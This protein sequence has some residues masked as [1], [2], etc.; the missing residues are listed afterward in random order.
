MLSSFLSRYAALSRI[1]S[2][3]GISAKLN[4]ARVPADR[5]IRTPRN[6][7]PR[8]P[9]MGWCP[10]H[11]RPVVNMAAGDELLDASG[12]VILDASGNVVLSDGAGDGCCCGQTC[13]SC[14]ISNTII[15]AA[16]GISVCSGCLD[17]RKLHGSPN[18]TWNVPYQATVFGTCC[19]YYSHFPGVI[20]SSSFNG[21]T[22]DNYGAG[23]CT[24]S[25]VSTDHAVSYFD[26]QIGAVGGV[27]KITAVYAINSVDSGGVIGDPVV[28]FVANQ[29][30]MSDCNSIVLTNEL[31]VGDCGGGGTSGYGCAFSGGTDIAIFGGYGGTLTLTL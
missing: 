1:S 29:I 22:F 5:T 23:D 27:L 10:V 7:F 4:P 28:V 31:G 14:S 18:T 8:R 11:R 2:A 30:A 26:F 16:S 6:F 3:K 13:F 21:M 15:A 9:R 12:N 24:G 17:G 20:P 19:R 25:V